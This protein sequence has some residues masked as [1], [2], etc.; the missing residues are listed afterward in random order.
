[1]ADITS[2]AG[3]AANTANSEKLGQ[4]TNRQ[5]QDAEEV[6]KLSKDFESIF[7]EI[8]LKSMRESVDK[9]N[10]IDGGNGE[11]IFQSMLDT[12][13]A[14]NLASQDMTGLSASIESHLT[15]LMDGGGKINE[16]QKAM[17]KAQY[18]RQKNDMINGP[19]ED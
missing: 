10:F 17:G 2:L 13:Y 4:L 6:K 5:P 1:M 18:I 19:K 11:Q 15:H 12:E 16:V 14:K 3:S 9:S 8:V 7:M